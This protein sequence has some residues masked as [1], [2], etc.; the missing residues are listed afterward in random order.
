[1]MV[2]V[3][4]AVKAD[5]TKLKPF[6]VFSGAKRDA[7]ALDEEYRHKCVA[8]ISANAWMNEESTLNW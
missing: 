4:L 7:K 1:M 5:E 3:C 6:I 8:N 2:T